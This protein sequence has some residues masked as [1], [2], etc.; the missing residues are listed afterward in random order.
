MRMS[1]YSNLFAKVTP[2]RVNL[3]LRP[4]PRLP[5][6]EGQM[7]LVVFVLWLLLQVF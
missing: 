1:S 7:R 2:T 6:I 5:G 3:G 4:V